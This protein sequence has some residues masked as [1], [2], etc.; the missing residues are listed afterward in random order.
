MKEII[1][2]SGISLISL[3]L[4]AIIILFVAGGFFV[5]QKYL[6]PWSKTYAQRFDDPRLQLIAHGLLA[7]SGHNMQP[8]KISLDNANPNVFYLYADSELLTPEVDSFARQTMVTQG[9]FLEYMRV[10]GV[11]LGFSTDLTLFPNGQY[12]EKNLKDSMKT[13]P[14]ARIS[15][16][17]AAPKIDLSYDALFLSDTNRAAYKTTELTPQQVI[18][19]EATNA[20]PAITIKIF[21]DKDN[22]AKLG[23]FALAGTKVENGVDRI[24]AETAMIFRS[25]ERQ[26]NQYRSGF[27]VEGQGT[28]GLMKFILQGLITIFPTTVSE[29]ASAKIANKS[30]QVAVD[31]TPAYVMI[32]TKDNSRANQAKAGMLYSRMIL[33]GHG[34]GLVM[35]P[36]SQI[37]EEYPEMDELYMKVH[38]E[39]A[40]DGGTI[41][42]FLRI[43]QPTKDFP[44]SMRRDVTSFIR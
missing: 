31:N 6:Q 36:L 18:K 42:M 29:S 34:V 24:N 40:P 8:W 22:L 14:V 38:K 30:T 3:L 43:G 39:Y 9:A 44:V 37:L 15:L 28:A 5:R 25:N 26:K 12:D 13:K 32:S 17:S 27:S 7:A 10:A 11:K 4:L 1:L 19:L 33:T 35:Q 2:I 23:D 20:D 16:A 21:Q 41:Q